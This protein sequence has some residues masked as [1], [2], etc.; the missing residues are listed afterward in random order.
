MAAKYPSQTLL[1]QS[2]SP[3]MEDRDEPMIAHQTE[4]DTD[5]LELVRHQT[6]PTEDQHGVLADQAAVVRDQL[7]QFGLDQE[8]ALQVAQETGKEKKKERKMSP[9][10]NRSELGSPN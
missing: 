9:R 7:Q 1:D 4:P 10:F 3:T 5:Q 6:E 2:K 8:S